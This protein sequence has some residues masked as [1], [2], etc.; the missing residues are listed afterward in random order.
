MAVRNARP[1][2][3][4][5]QEFLLSAPWAFGAV[6]R[7]IWPWLDEVTASKAGAAERVREGGA[8][9]G[10]WGEC[11]YPGGCSLSDVGPWNPS[12]SGSETESEGEVAASPTESASEK[13]SPTP[14]LTNPPSALTEKILL[15]HPVTTQV[16]PA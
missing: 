12:G 5:Q 7:A 16:L 2:E 14:T 9:E 4:E 1:P 11:E 10:V 15:K 13:T 8:A 6:W 3:S